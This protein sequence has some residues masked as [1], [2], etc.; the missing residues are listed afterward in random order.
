MQ[1]R[2]WL[3]L[4]TAASLALAACSGDDDDDDDSADTDASIGCRND[5]RAEQYAANLEKVGDGGLFTFVLKTADPAPPGKG[6]NA[7]TLRIMDATGAAVT[8]ATVTLHPFMPDH[9]HGTSVVPQVQVDGDGYT[10]Q[11]IYLFMAGL[12]EVT[13]EA[14]SGQDTDS[15]VVRFCIE[16]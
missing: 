7:W 10:V 5:P 15:A 3:A 13:I 4:A 12:W 9:G 16:G 14:T 6:V 2:G 11:N 8:G 1:L